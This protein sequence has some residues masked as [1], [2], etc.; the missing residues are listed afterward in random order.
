[1]SQIR[2]YAKYLFNTEITESAQYIPRDGALPKRNCKVIIDEEYL[3]T[4]QDSVQVNNS[5]IIIDVIAD[6]FPNITKGDIFR[7]GAKD[8]M[9]LYIS[10]E[11]EGIISLGVGKP[12]YRMYPMID[13]SNTPAAVS[14]DN[15]IAKIKVI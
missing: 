7:I 13:S 11:D 6:E 8:Y 9:V 14:P 15:E 10:P 5:E 1:M 3:L 2:N 4:T 12:N